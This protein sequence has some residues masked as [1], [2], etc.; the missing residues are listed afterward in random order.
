M[1]D[2]LDDLLEDNPSSKPNAT[3]ATKLNINKFGSSKNSNALKDDFDDLND[4]NDVWGFGN[5]RSASNAKPPTKI[6][7]E[8][9]ANKDWGWG[10][11]KTDMRPSGSKA[12]LNSSF[13]GGS[14][15]GSM[16]GSRKSKAEQEADDL[17]AML[18][19]VLEDTKPDDNA[20]AP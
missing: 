2:D 16:G 14:Q 19:D 3:V 17:D 6:P 15:K 1:L 7:A 5:S 10:G 18:G 13:G 4:D 12:G 20:G 8:T 9:S 11:S